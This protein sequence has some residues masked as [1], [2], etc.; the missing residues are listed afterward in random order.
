[1]T[2]SEQREKWRTSYQQMNKE[3]LVDEAVRQRSMRESLIHKYLLVV[4]KLG[5]VKRILRDV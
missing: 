2:T 1:M 3:Q 5:D 4:K